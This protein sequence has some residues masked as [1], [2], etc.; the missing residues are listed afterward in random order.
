LS[1]G[2]KGLVIIYE[3]IS[4]GTSLLCKIE[5]TLLQSIFSRQIFL[6]YFGKGKFG[7]K[8]FTLQKSEFYFA[9]EF[10]PFFRQAKSGI[11][12]Y[13]DYPYKAVVLKLF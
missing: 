13:G 7:G 4:S 12:L 10:F 1:P 9:K 3:H 11:E 5:S 8:K 6:L 2:H